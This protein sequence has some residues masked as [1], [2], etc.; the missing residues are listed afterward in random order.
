MSLVLD[1]SHDEGEETFTLAP[2]NASGAWLEETEA[3]GTIENRDLMPAA[4]LARCGR[5]TAEQKAPSWSVSFWVG[6]R[7]SGRLKRM[8]LS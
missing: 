5:A 8:G 6:I 7:C 3:T 4:L 1:D 2:S